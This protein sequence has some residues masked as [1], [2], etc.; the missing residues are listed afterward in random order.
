MIRKEEVFKIGKIGKPHGLRGEVSFLYD[1]DVFDT[2]EADYLVLEVEGILVPFFMEEYR[3]HGN[4]TALM[5][6]CDIDTVEQARE[7]T[8]CD[9]FFPHSLSEERED[10]SWAQIIGCSLKDH[11]TGQTI[12]IIR[13]VDDATLNT[14]FEIETPDGRNIL[15]PASEELITKVDAGKRVITC[16]L[17]E[18]LLEL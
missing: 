5:K 13:S 17:P 7:L 12:G 6:F 8:G 11:V 4:G 1:D 9:V 14:L 15:V 18:G 16:S 10:L 3:F 2:T